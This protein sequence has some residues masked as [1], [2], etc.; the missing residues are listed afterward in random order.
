M[1]F[2]LFLGKRTPRFEMKKTKK[3]TL[4]EVLA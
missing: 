4:F 3:D 1:F 2:L